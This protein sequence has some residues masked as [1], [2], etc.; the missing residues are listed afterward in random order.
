MSEDR[1]CIHETSGR[2]CVVCDLRA[3]IAAT[4]RERD[5]ALDAL[6]A[7]DTGRRTG[8]VHREMYAQMMRERDEAR[9][10][11]DAVE[12]H[13]SDLRESE[14]RYRRL[15]DAALRERDGLRAAAEKAVTVI[16]GVLMA[17]GCAG[18]G[19][20]CREKSPNPGD[21]CPMCSIQSGL[22]AIESAL[23]GD[24]PAPP[25]DRE[26]RCPRCGWPL[27]KSIREGCVPGNCSYRPKEGSEEWKRMR[28]R[29]ADTAT[30]RTALD[31]YLAG[32][33]DSH[34]RCATC[35]GPWDD[36]GMDCPACRKETK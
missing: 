28:D 6:R 36:P 1:V 21:W 34:G 32:K 16:G 26:D 18:D 17:E 35:G 15:L 8:L 22:S 2:V 30:A 23:S 14:A 27:A 33:T 19:E 4:E 11:L 9:A 13:R 12:K 31:S 5:E 7:H 24:P 20:M 10:K 25:R 29:E 3:K